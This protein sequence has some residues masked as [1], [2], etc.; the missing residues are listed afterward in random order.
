[1]V[2]QNKIY[3][4]GKHA[5]AEA[6]RYAPQVVRK[7]HLAPAMDDKTLRDL[8][9]STGVATEPLDK[10]KVSSMVE[11]GAPHQGVVALISLGSV[12]VSAEQFFDTFLPTP[13][14]LLVLLSE[15]QDP[16]NV[17]AV[18]RSAVAFGASAVLIPT[19]KQ[20]PITGSV[21]KASAGMAFRVP[22]VA[23]ENMQQTIAGLKKKGV[24]VLGLSAEGTHSVQHEAFA[25]AT[26]LVLGNEAQGL[27][28]AARALC[29]RMLSIPI[30]PKAES[31]NVAASAAVALYAWSLKH[32]V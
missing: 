16:H 28:P 3:I 20:S 24:A 13:N 25:Q 12:M 32:P 30:D 11:G 8:I 27:A 31:L 1:M 19:H 7:V 17:G 22:I 5:V 9:R 2:V 10:N 26:L 23:V 29:E 6:L 15:V 4:Y 18:I 14:T 21:V